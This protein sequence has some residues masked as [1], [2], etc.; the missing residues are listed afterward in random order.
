M[1]LRTLFLPVL[2]LTA[3]VIYLTGCSSKTVEFPSINYSGNK[4]Y[5]SGQVVWRDLISPDPAK[6]IEFY[7]KVFGWTA[8]KSGTEED[9]YW[10]F[11]LDGKPVA[12][13]YQMKESGKKAGGEWV[14]YYSLSKQE[15]FVSKAKP[16][17]AA[18]I[19]KPVNIPGRGKVSL[20]TD[21]AGAYFALINSLN[22]DPNASEPKDFEFLWSELWSND[23]DKSTVFYKDSFNF[24]TESKKDD[25]RDY[26]ILK[27]NEKLV[28]GIIK[29]PAENVRDHWVQYVRVNDVREMEEKAKLAGAKILIPADVKIRKGTV[30]VFLDPTGAPIAVQKWPIE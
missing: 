24:Q 3:V 2:F 27:N 17:G 29:N 14:Q 28:S 11:K 9:P 21:P 18:Q 25:N 8:V 7:K 4:E 20:Y 1:N 10:L 13:M 6:S 26:I 30:S 15:D 19:L 12:G 23:P 5:N 16:L 22:G